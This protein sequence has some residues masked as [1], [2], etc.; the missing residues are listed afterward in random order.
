MEYNDS[1]T[2]KYFG[3]I[4]GKL[5]IAS[6]KILSKQESHPFSLNHKIKSTNK[7]YCIIFSNKYFLI[8]F[9]LQNEKTKFSKNLK[10]SQIKKGKSSDFIAEFFEEKIATQNEIKFPKD[11]TFSQRKIF[12]NYI[13]DNNKSKELFF[14]AIQENRSLFKN[15][16]E[17]FST[18]YNKI[19]FRENNFKKSPNKNSKK[20]KIKNFP[21]L[22]SCSVNDLGNFP[23]FETVI[24][25]KSQIFPLQNKIIL[26][27]IEVNDNSSQIDLDAFI[28]RNEILNARESHCFKV[29]PIIGRELLNFKHI[30]KRI[31]SGYNSNFNGKKNINFININDNLKKNLNFELR[32]INVNQNQSSPTHKGNMYNKNSSRPQTGRFYPENI[33]D[34]ENLN[35]FY[36]NKNE[37]RNNPDFSDIRENKIYLLENNNLIINHNYES[38]Y[39]NRDFIVNKISDLELEN[40]KNKINIAVQKNEISN[41]QYVITGE[42]NIIINNPEKKIVINQNKENLCKNQQEIFEENKINFISAQEKKPSKNLIEEKI[43]KNSF[44]N[45]E[46]KKFSKNSLKNNNNIYDHSIEN[47]ESDIMYTDEGIDFF[48]IN[49]NKTFTETNFKNFSNL[50]LDLTFNNENNNTELNLKNNSIDYINIDNSS[51]NKNPQVE[52]SNDKISKINP[53]PKSSISFIN[54]N[55]IR[56]GNKRLFLKNNKNISKKKISGQKTFKSEINQVSKFQDSPPIISKNLN[57]KTTNPIEDFFNLNLNAN[58]MLKN[59]NINKSTMKNDSNDKIEKLKIL[60]IIKE[61]NKQALINHPLPKYLEILKNQIKTKINLGNS[62]NLNDD[63]E[64]LEIKNRYRKKKINIEEV[65]ILH[66]ST[67]R[68]DINPLK[69]SENL[70][71]ASFNKYGLNNFEGNKYNRKSIINEVTN[72]RSETISIKREYLHSFEKH[73]IVD[74]NI[75]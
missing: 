55:F 41:S 70:M 56:I 9:R 68:K 35:C 29:K 44:K 6:K 20:D 49:K 74:T 30:P 22:K 26:K 45:L 47:T 43:L 31:L 38:Y 64:N 59:S 58:N 23:N 19:L 42:S 2:V 37:R 36:E 15:K 69:V 32:N 13:Q 3:S 67:I 14:K 51:S 8:F 57:K 17:L 11:K 62:Q 34:Y 10:S 1:Y 7:K 18:F 72:N 73:A 16:P 60:R 71:K 40:D 50:L 75:K 25:E 66:N 52:Y 65:L 46:E 24:T 28:K 63:W 39:K 53:R 4:S 27:N 12:S 54:F 61:K 21:N 33:L 48:S 5:G